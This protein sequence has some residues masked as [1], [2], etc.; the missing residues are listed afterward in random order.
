MFGNHLVV[1]NNLAE[2]NI[3]AVRAFNIEKELQR[4]TGE[5]NRLI[6]NESDK[7]SSGVSLLIEEARTR[8]PNGFDYS[9]NPQK[10]GAG[11]RNAG[12]GERQQPERGGDNA[13]DRGT[14]VGE[15]NGLSSRTYKKRNSVLGN[16]T[17][18]DKTSDGGKRNDTATPQNAVSRS[19]DTKIF[20][21]HQI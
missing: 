4:I 6:D 14:H 20:R 7:I 13:L 16:T 10:R 21:F 3:S 8:L 17:D 19:K 1:V 11:M 18:T 5:I 9:S 15:D 12:M 2:G